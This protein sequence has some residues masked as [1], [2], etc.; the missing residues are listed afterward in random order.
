[1]YKHT[2]SSTYFSRF[3]DAFIGLWISG[4]GEGIPLVALHNV[5]LCKP[6]WGADRILVSHSQPHDLQP[7]FVLWYFCRV[8]GEVE[9]PS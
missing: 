9:P 1:M 8:L 2:H 6:C 3:Q 7:C 4:D 5:V